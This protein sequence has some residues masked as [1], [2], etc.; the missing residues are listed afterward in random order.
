MLGQIGVLALIV[1]TPVPTRLAA[2]VDDVFALRGN[3]AGLG[4]LASSE[5]RLLYG[6]ESLD[7]RGRSDVHGVGLYG[8][9]RLLDGLTLAA[10]ADFGFANEGGVRE[11][12]LVGAAFGAGPARLGVALEHLD[13]LGFGGDTRVRVG[14]QV[15]PSR[16]IS[17]AGAGRDLSETFGNRQWDLGLA[18]R[19]GT[20]R[21][22]VSSQWRLTESVPVNGET[23]DLLFLLRAE[24]ISGLLVGFAFDHDFDRFN[25]QVAFDFARTGLETAVFRNEIADGRES[26]AVAV[27]SVLREDPVP[28]LIEPSTFIE[29]ELQGNLKPPPDFNLFAGGF[30]F[31]VYGWAPLALEQAAVS[32]HVHGLLVRLGPLDVGWGKAWELHRGLSRVSKQ[33]KDVYCF[34][35]G[36]GPRELLVASA[37]DEI[38]MLPV[39]IFDVGGTATRLLTVG[40]GLRRFGVDVEAHRRG[41]YKTAPELFTRD[42][43]SEQAVETAEALLDE[44]YGTWVEAL[45]RGRNLSEAR[46]GQ[47]VA[48]GSATATVA[49]ATGLVDAT[50]HRDEFERW[51]RS[52]AGP[53]IVSSA[54]DL[55]RRE[56]PRWTPGPEV[57]LI[58]IDAPISR[59]DSFRLPFGLGATAGAD[60]LLEALRSAGSNPAVRAVVLRIDTPGGDAVA[61]DRIAHGVKEL[62]RKKPVVV[63]MGDVAASGGYY[64]AAP[65]RSIWAEPTTV[66]G[67]IGV[68]NL[69]FSVYR[70]LV[71]LGVSVRLLER[72]EHAG[73]ADPLSP[74]DPADAPVLESQ[75]EFLYRRFLQVVADGRN[76]SLDRVEAVAAGRVWSG[77]AARERGLVDDLGGLADAIRHAQRLAGLEGRPVRVR[78]APQKRKG[79]P[80]ALRKLSPGA[81]ADAAPRSPWS[82]LPRDL[83]V[84]AAAMLAV[85]TGPAALPEI[86]VQ[87]D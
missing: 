29:L 71:R 70:L 36:A 40:E 78:V 81:G 51:A 13:P 32:E 54:Q 47:L 20:E 33:G 6:F 69:R 2:D 63:S 7:P 85:R 80:R 86:W 35:E 45:A 73:L 57:A 12:G 62:A 61:S 39:G 22:Q 4:H 46:V 49:E 66:T 11:R 41:A 25:G 72:G 30:R 23:L 15:R 50:F 26:T 60:T 18:F 75:V 74:L 83:R 24:P 34:V 14:M 19:P 28:S 65:A 1:A 16:W 9:F 82:W 10:G 5:L 87:V 48:A 68:F 37:C 64:V 38:A 17:L 58:V 43:P 31:G 76:M 3:P 44:T 42:E 55:M 53:F 79:L 52:R 67:S 21:V 56:R 59:G 8:G 84:M 27:N 77:R